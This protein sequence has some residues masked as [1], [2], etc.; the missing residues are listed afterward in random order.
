MSNSA[1]VQEIIHQIPTSFASALRRRRRPRQRGQ[2][3]QRPG[4]QAVCAAVPSHTSHPPILS[5][6]PLTRPEPPPP[7]PPTPSPPMSPPAPWPPLAKRTRKATKRCCE[8]KLLRGV[9]VEDNFCVP[10][11]SPY[12]SSGPITAAAEPDADSFSNFRAA[13]LSCRPPLTTGNT[14]SWNSGLCPS[15]GSEYHLLNRRLPWNALFAATSGPSDIDAYIPI[16]GSK[17]LLLTTDILWT[18]FIAAMGGHCETDACF[19]S[20]GIVIATYVT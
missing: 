9:G 18:I 10:P 5:A 20:A 16:P 14:A 4:G 15:S 8:V 6:P 19:A 1:G 12:A 17:H 13:A 11:S 7:E 2:A 3:A